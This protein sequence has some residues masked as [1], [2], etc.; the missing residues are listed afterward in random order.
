MED[1][2]VRLAKHLEN[3]VMGYPVAYIGRGVCAVSCPTQAISIVR[4]KGMADAPENFEALH[5]SISRERGLSPSPVS[6]T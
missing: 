4:R 2:Y 5:Q 1:I 6:S 3:L